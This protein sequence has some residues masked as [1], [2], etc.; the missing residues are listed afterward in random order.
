MQAARQDTERLQQIVDDLL[1]LSR[2]QSGRMELHRRHVSAESLVRESVLPFAA[3]ARDKNVTLKTELFPGLGEIDVDTERMQLVLA[4][5]IG[6]AVRY[7]PAGGTV[8]VRARPSDT[9]TV[10]EVEDTG[11]GIPKQYQT[12]VFDKFFRMPGSGSGGAGLGL[13]IAKEITMAHGARLTLQSEAGQGSLFSIE[14]P[15]VTAADTEP[16][17]GGRAEWSISTQSRTVESR[18]DF[19]HAVRRRRLPDRTR[20]SRPRCAG[21]GA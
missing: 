21:A 19:R 8:V 1:D 13:Y 17:I 5:L 18:L 14:L 20:A 4:N 7:T 2:I 9:A 12:A 6:N 11:P 10:I 3:A 16:P 15:T